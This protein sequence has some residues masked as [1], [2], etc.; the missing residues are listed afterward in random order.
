MWNSHKYWRK[1]AF[2]MLPNK[3]WQFSFDIAGS[4]GY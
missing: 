1:V 4:F 2:A 3:L